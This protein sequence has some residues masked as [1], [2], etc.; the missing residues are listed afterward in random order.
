MFGQFIRRDD[1]PVFAQVGR[2]QEFDASGMTAPIAPAYIN[3][4]SVAGGYGNV[5]KQN[6]AGIFAAVMPVIG[7]GIFYFPVPVCISFEYI[8]FINGN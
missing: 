6:G 1:F 2:T 7:E 3:G 5:I 4:I 8:V